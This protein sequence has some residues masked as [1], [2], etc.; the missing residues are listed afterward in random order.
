[1]SLRTGVVL[2]NFGGPSKLGEVRPFLYR[3]FCD[4]EIM[5]A[6][7][8]PFRQVFALLIS[9]ARSPVSRRMYRSMGGR[10]PLL[11]WTQVQASL[12][13]SLLS[14]HQELGEFRVEI[15]MR[16]WKPEIRLALTNLKAWG[17]DQV[18]L[19]S[20]FP[21][22]SAVTTKSCLAEAERQLQRMAWSPTVIQVTNWHRD[23]GYVSLVKNMVADALRKSVGTTHVLFSA[24]GIPEKVARRGD[25]YVRQIEETVASLTDNLTVPWSLAYQSQIGPVRWMKPSLHSEIR[26]LSQRK[27]Q[28]LI[29]VPVSFVCDHV[30]TLYELDQKCASLAESVGISRYVRIPAF[31]GSSEFATIIKDIVCREVGNA[32][33]S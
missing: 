12:I 26:R 32:G 27:L 15:G 21:Q 2:L 8:G 29:V 17:A 3:L 28:T 33:K 22:Y 7:R 6:I 19:V 10:S 4:S 31:N 23:P 16:L 24:H 13:Q 11:Y 9:W 1:M 18:A 25:P 5:P 20:M 30:E 14:T